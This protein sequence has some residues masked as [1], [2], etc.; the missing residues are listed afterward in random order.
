MFKLASVL[1]EKIK[2]SLTSATLQ[3]CLV[4]MS[5]DCNRGCDSSCDGSC[6]EHCLH[7]TDFW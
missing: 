1:L 6:T 7:N 5:S 4:N 3:P 2:S